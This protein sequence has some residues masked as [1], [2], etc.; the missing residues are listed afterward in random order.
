MKRIHETFKF[1]IKG[2]QAVFDTYGNG[3]GMI[4]D[5]GGRN[6][7]TNHPSYPGKQPVYL[8]MKTLGREPSFDLSDGSKGHALSHSI[9]F[10]VT[11]GAT[12]I[13]MDSMIRIAP[14]NPNILRFGH[15]GNRWYI[16]FCVPLFGIV[17]AKEI[18]FVKP[19]DNEWH[20]LAY[21]VKFNKVVGYFDDKDNNAFVLPYTAAKYA[22]P[23]S[24][25]WNAILYSKPEFKINYQDIDFGIN[26]L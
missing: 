21:Q 14:G 1:L 18:S 20:T 2:Q 17:P 25:T 26:N 24:A 10:R 19:V 22:T 9:N 13:I 15:D 8:E 12:G 4:E 16:Y 7:I 3:V 23:D 6:V 11:K 5:D